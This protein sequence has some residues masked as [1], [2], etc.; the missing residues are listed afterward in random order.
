MRQL[1]KQSIGI[2]FLSLLAPMAFAADLCGVAATKS[3]QDLAIYQHLSAAQ[4]L[5][6]ENN[7]FPRFVKYRKDK[8]QEHG[9]MFKN[10]N[11]FL[12]EKLNSS[13]SCR[14]KM[15]SFSDRGGRPID[16][17]I[18]DINNEY[19]K[20]VSSG[21]AE[22]NLFCQRADAL[23]SAEEGGSVVSSV[24]SNIGRNEFAAR[25]APRPS[26]TISYSSRAG[27]TLVSPGTFYKKSYPALWLEPT[28]FVAGVGYVPAS[29]A[30][31]AEALAR[32]A[33]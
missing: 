13:S 6:T 9:A 14:S 2:L 10:I 30:Q 20:Y 3:G 12:A 24:N 4:N 23:L 32:S 27:G 17:L 7:F 19:M 15:T 1:K 21:M 25:V 28:V 29:R 5:C 22:R 26:K 11:A 16:M 8:L 18:T 33:K 31:K